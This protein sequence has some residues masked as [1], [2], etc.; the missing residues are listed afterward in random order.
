MRVYRLRH[1]AGVTSSHVRSDLRRCMRSHR[2]R[3]GETKAKVLLVLLG[4][5]ASQ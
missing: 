3:L 2:A 5:Y 4:Q 1:H